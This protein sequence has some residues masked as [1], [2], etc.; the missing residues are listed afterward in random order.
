M[1]KWIFLF[2]ALTLVINIAAMGIGCKGKEAPKPAA[3][4][5]AKP[6]EAPAPAAPAATPAPEKPAEAPKK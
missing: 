3:K 5:E 2:L 6:A 1:K 4:E